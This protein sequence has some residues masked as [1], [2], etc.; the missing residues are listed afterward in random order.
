LHAPR[1]FKARLQDAL[2]R[3]GLRDFVLN[4]MLAFNAAVGNAWVRGAI[5]IKEGHLYVEIVQSLQRQSMARRA[6]C[7]APL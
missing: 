4:A 3:R 1:L 7:L 5:A 6:L 2:A